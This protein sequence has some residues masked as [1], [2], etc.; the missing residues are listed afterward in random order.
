VWP[1]VFLIGGLGLAAW[2][3]ASTGLTSVLDALRA[4]GLGGLAAVVGVHLIAIALMASAWWTLHR[5]GRPATFFL[6]RLVRDAGSEVLPLSQMGGLMLAVCVLMRDGVASAVATAA[7]LVDAAL[8]FLAQAGYLA[9]ALALAVSLAPG[10]TAPLPL[11]LPAA[12]VAATVGAGAMLWRGPPRRVRDLATRLARRGLGAALD[13]IVAVRAEILVIGRAKPALA[14]SFV[15]HL[16]AWIVSGV[17][18]WLGLRFMGVPLGLGTVLA[19]EGLVYGTRCLGFMVPNA[20]GI[21]EG[22][23]V[24]LGASFGLAP[25][26]ALGLSLLKRGRDLAIG[27]PVLVAWHLLETRRALAKDGARELDPNAA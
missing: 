5:A 8:E 4:V 24:V 20:I 13:R 22:A 1:V 7:T 23:Y 2:L 26:F 16:A 6:G 12:L 9:L 18:A 19:I 14:V 10:G 27:I 21:Q 15:L 11:W 17:E 25:E 3:V